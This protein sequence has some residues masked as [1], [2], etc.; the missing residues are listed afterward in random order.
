MHAGKFLGREFLGNGFF[1]LSYRPFP[2][3]FTSATA[4]IWKESQEACAPTSGFLTAPPLT[5]SSP[6]WAERGNPGLVVSCI[7]R[8]GSFHR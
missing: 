4:R 7:A 1:Y 3:E 2:M 8:S 6:T 5:A